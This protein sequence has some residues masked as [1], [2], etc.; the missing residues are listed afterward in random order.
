MDREAK[1]PHRPMLEEAPTSY[2]VDDGD[3]DEK[4]PF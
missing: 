2:L 1:R 4:V 3:G